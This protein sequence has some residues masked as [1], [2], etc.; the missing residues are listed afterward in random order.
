MDKI[1]CERFRNILGQKEFSYEQIFFL[2][3]KSKQS[4]GGMGMSPK[5]D[6]AAFRKNGQAPPYVATWLIEEVCRQR[7]ISIIT[8]QQKTSL[9]PKNSPGIANHLET[10]TRILGRMEMDEY[11]TPK[12]I[13]DIVYPNGPSL[14]TWRQFQQNGYVPPRVVS[15][16]KE[17]LC[18]LISHGSDKNIPAARSI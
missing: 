3:G 7:N 8:G 17:T 16:M 14:W 2:A 4:K 15:F 5:T 6:L 12:K 1:K 13:F 9:F 10:I 18:P 11:D